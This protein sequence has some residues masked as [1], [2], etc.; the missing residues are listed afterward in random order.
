MMVCSWGNCFQI[1]RH[2]R[3][4]LESRFFSSIK[5]VKIKMDPRL[6]G[7]DDPANDQACGRCAAGSYW[8][9]G[10]DNCVIGSLLRLK[11]PPPG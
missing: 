2:S 5:R 6:R 1:R 3:K 9:A 10:S 11:L 8:P 4:K 7:D